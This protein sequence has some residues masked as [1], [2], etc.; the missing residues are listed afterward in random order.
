MGVWKANDGM[1]E[2]AEA[3]A[4]NGE[5]RNALSNDDEGRMQNPQIAAI[6]RY[7]PR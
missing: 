1:T 5:C 3:V 7:L 4:G 6:L 2:A